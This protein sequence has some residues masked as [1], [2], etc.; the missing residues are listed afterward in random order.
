MKNEHSHDPQYS[1]GPRDIVSPP[2]NSNQISQWSAFNEGGWNQDEG[3]GGNGSQNG[4]KLRVEAGLLEDHTNLYELVRACVQVDISTIVN[5]KMLVLDVNYTG[6]S[7]SGYYKVDKPGIIDPTGGGGELNGDFKQQMWARIYARIGGNPVMVDYQTLDFPGGESNF[8]YTRGDNISNKIV[9][10]GGY[11]DQSP[12]FVFLSSLAAGV[13]L[14]IQ[15][16]ILIDNSYSGDG[17]FTVSH[18]SAIT[19]DVAH[20]TVTQVGGDIS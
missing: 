18:E 3:K 6:I 8:R 12:R 16:G 20:L 19:A 14:N 7:A 1:H 13:R 5:L 2:Y 10:F 15:V 9:N 11:A 4:S 17:K